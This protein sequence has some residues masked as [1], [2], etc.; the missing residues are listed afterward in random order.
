MATTKSAP[1]KKTTSKVKAVEQE[2]EKVVTEVEAFAKELEGKTV[3]EL[4]ILQSD[5]LVA[6]SEAKRVV[7]LLRQ[8]AANMASTVDVDVEA[9]IVKAKE[10]WAKSVEWLKAVEKKLEGEFKDISGIHKF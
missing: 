5:A 6:E 8:R 1:A 3:Q 7:V 10:D 9:D 2:V 4:R